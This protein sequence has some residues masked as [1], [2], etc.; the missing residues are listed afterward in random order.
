MACDLIVLDAASRHELP[1]HF[2]VNLAATV[3]AGGRVVAQRGV[4]CYRAEESQ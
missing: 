1:Y 4:P 3:V 2:G